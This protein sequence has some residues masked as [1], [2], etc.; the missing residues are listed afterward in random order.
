MD[1]ILVA[2]F[3]SQSGAD[4][5]FQ[6]LR[7]LH[8]AGTIT[9]YSES[10]ATKDASGKT[11]ITRD[12]PSGPLG[13]AVGLLTGSLLGVLGG[14]V[15]VALG[16][17]AGTMGGAVYDLASLGVGADFVDQVAGL[18][19]PGKW[20]VVAEVQEEQVPPVDARLVAAG[21]VV[22]RRER[23]DVIDDQLARDAAALNADL[24]EL[25]AEFDRAGEEARA[26]LQA[27][28]DATRAKLQAIHN[29]AR[30]EAEAS[31]RE[32]DAKVAALQAQA[33]TAQA[34][35]KQQIEERLA[36]V[37]AQYRE[38]TAKLDR[39]RQLTREALRPGGGDGAAAEETGAATNGHPAIERV[40]EGMIVVGS[41]GKEIG[42]VAL[43]RMG[44]PEAVSTEGQE[45]TISFVTLGYHDEPDVP[46]DLRPG[47][48][49]MGYV[50][51][52]RGGILGIGEKEHYVRSD[53]I[54]NVSGDQVLL[55]VTEAQLPDEQAN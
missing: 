22:Y 11:R 43:I 6:A 46:E 53:R 5:G 54:A 18:L 2:V 23:A 42:K 4:Q 31:R 24:D 30:A 26:G 20:A 21:G 38:R 39:A 3:D 36:E 48:V 37:R 7:D 49:R 51:V 12:S 33:A 27:R 14:P 52:E 55:T 9:L 19:E 10:V 47:L 41:D 40:R 15:G 34:E 29:R 25:D 13:T 45:R 35:R 1:K 17:T 50:K 44:D 32:A 28:I 16:A 8:D